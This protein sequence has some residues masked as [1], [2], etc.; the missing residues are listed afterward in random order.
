VE[1]PGLVDSLGENARQ[2]FFKHFSIDR[3]GE[4]FSVLIERVQKEKA[5]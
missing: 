5:R 1:E 2:T 3:L 4:R